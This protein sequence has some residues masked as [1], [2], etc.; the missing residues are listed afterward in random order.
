MT[1]PQTL[2]TTST[3]IQYRTIQDLNRTIQANLDKVPSGTEVLAGVH[4]S[5]Q[6]AAQLIASQLNLPCISVRNL[7]ETK[8]VYTGYRGYLEPEEQEEYLAK[9]RKVLVVEDATTSGATLIKERHR[10][11]N[12]MF[13]T[14]HDITY[15]TVYPA[16]DN[17]PGIDLW[18]EVVPGPR[19]FEWNWMNH[20]LMTKGVVSLDNILCYDPPEDMDKSESVY[21][22]YVARARLRY[23]PRRLLTSIVSGRLTKYQSLT[24]QWLRRHEFKVSNVYLRRQEHQQVPR[25]KAAAYAALPEAQIFFE[26]DLDT[27]NFIYNSTLRPVFCVESKELLQQ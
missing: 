1:V 19:L 24:V 10:I 6:L 8:W 5:G 26:H 2:K 22:Q 12:S 15:L 27:A 14:S 25:F 13:A 7:C 3:K 16:A 11:E 21:R 17:V 4:R 9:P 20:S 23:A 18:M